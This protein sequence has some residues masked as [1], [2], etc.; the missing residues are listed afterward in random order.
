MNCI[1]AKREDHLATVILNRPE[2]LNALNTEMLKEL[3]NMLDLLADDKNIRVVIV[4]GAGEKSFVAGADVK[5]MSGLN[6]EEAFH[7]ARY[8]QQVFQKVA[9]LPQPVIAAINGFALGG[10]CELALACDLR[11]ASANAVFSQPEVTLGIIPG[12]GATQRLTL[13]VGAAKA[14]ELIFTGKKIT[15]DE[16]YALGLVHQV[17]A[18][19]LAQSAAHDL[20]SKLAS[21][22]PFALTQAKFAINYSST[23]LLEQGLEKEAGCFSACFTTSD[24]IEG[25]DSFIAKRKPRFTGK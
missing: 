4:T 2:A 23:L 18:Y 20:A 25:M 8:G 14:K 12:F 19:G 7:F 21:L 11:I 13:L 3:D 22:A 1:I 15:A 16:A 6:H 10:G 24:R 5:E 9:S 17:V